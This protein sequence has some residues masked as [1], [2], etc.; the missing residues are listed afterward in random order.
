[1]SDF[2]TPDPGGAGGAGPAAGVQTPPGA[3]GTQQPQPQDGFRQLFPNIPEEHWSILEPHVREV[4]GH[5]SRLEQQLAPFK[6]F[7]DAG[8]DAQAAGNLIRF[9][10]DFERD[11]LTMWLQ[12]GRMLQ[13]PG[14]QGQSVVDPEVDLDYLEAIAKGEDPDEGVGGA[15][16]VPGQQGAQNDQVPPEL[17]QY[18][19]GL[20]QRIDQL[21]NGFQQQQV[22]QQERVQ[23]RMLQQTTNTIREQVKASGYPEELLTDEEIHTRLMMTRGNMQA[24]IKSFV[25]H[26]NG[27]LK[28]YT[29]PRTDPGSQG[30]EMPNGA[31]PTTPRAPEPKDAWGKARQSASAR[32]RRNNS[33]AA[34]NS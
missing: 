32:M 22:S 11:P 34:Q 9:S 2:S 19:Q 24:A 5:V 3:Q 7:A 27:L 15:P 28:N 8:L 14:Q 16:G 33:A 12:M 25:D 23:D 6:P 30:L 1:M 10:A 13:Q 31:P 21:Q 29:E 26:R 4:Q 18:I 20:E 17:A